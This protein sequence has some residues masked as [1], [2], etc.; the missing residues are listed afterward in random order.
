MNVGEGKRWGHQKTRHYFPT[1]AR[2]VGRFRKWPCILRPKGSASAV[3]G[4]GQPVNASVI[5]REA[6]RMRSAQH[7]F[8]NVSSLVY[9]HFPSFR[10]LAMYTYIKVAP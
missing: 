5:V 2:G 7:K 8:R 1:A 3:T 9:R 10:N 6:G 4:L